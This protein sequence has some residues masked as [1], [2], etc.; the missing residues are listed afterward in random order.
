VLLH[1]T[2][3]HTNS[4]YIMPKF[5]IN[6][7]GVYKRNYSFMMNIMDKIFEIRRCIEILASTEGTNSTQT[8]QT[9][10]KQT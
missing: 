8:N 4:G 5:I 2:H 9:Y 6:T 10:N 7:N 3:K 1:I